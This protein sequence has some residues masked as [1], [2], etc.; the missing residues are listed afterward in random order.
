MRHLNSG[1]KNNKGFSLV[2]L[3]IVIAIMVALVAVMAPTFIKYVQKS[4]DAVIYDAASTALSVMKAE[5][6]DGH[7]TGSGVVRVAADSEGNIKLTFEENS[8]GEKLSYVSDQGVEGVEG[9]IQTC[10]ALGN[11]HIKSKVAYYIELD[12]SDIYAPKYTESE[13]KTGMT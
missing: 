4:R 6:S 9:F 10:G 12:G 7:L 2:E 13:N 1:K 8:K 3:I 5:Y 11:G